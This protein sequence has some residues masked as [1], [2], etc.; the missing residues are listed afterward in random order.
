MIIVTVSNLFPPTFSVSTVKLVSV[1]EYPEPPLLTTTLVTAPP[2]I[3]KSAVK[4]IPEPPNRE[5]P[6]YVPST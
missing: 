3:V 4:P 5:T 1:F 2:L 6:V